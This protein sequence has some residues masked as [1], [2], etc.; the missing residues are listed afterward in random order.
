MRKTSVYLS[1]Q[2][3]ARLARLAKVRGKSHAEI[4]REGLYALEREQRPDR[5]FAM[6]GVVEGDGTNISEIPEED[7]L[8]GFGND[9]YR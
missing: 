2:D 9:S 6:A 5:N 4:V 7:L 1:E 3:R 8:Q